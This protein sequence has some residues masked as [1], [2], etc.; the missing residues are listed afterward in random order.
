MSERQN[1]RYRRPSHMKPIFHKPVGADARAHVRELPP[2]DK[3]PRCING[4]R[5]VLKHEAGQRQH[6]SRWLNSKSSAEWAE[7]RERDS[8]C[9]NLGGEA[10][11]VRSSEE[12][13]PIQASG[14]CAVK[15]DGRGWSAMAEKRRSAWRRLDCVQVRMRGGGP[16]R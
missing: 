13:Q 14:K 11:Y 15:I 7:I 9:L 2:C 8:L 10:A 5:R 12:R 6:K 4:G 3:E 16:S 1:P